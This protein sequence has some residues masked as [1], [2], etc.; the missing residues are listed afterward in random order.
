MQEVAWRAWKPLRAA[1]LRT[2][3]RHGEARLSF[4]PL[5]YYKPD[6]GAVGEA[7]A[8]IVQF[9]EL[10][11]A[12]EFP[13]LGYETVALGFPPP[14]NVDF[15]TGFQWE[16]MP[17][18]EVMPVV[19]YNG[20]DVKVPWELSRLQFLPVLAKAYLLTKDARFRQAAKVLFSDWREKNPVGVGVN[21]TL[22]MESALRGMSLCL[23]LS[24][25][26]PLGPEEQKW[27]RE[28]TRSIWE[29][30]LFTEAALE[31]SHLIRGNHYLA[32][33]VGLSCM[34]SFLDGPGME[35]RRRVYR[36][37]V[38]REMLRQVYEDG[39]NYEAS[40]CYHFLV[41]QLFTT[42][43]LLMRADGH[44]PPSPFL[45]RLR[46]MFLY[47]EALAGKDERVPHV[48]DS[49]DGRAE[50][51][52]TDL[53]QMVSLPCERRDSLLVS[54]Y[55][56]LG[57]ALFNL[58]RTHGDTSDCA[59]YGLQPR[60]VTPSPSRVSLFPQSGV[61]IGRDNGAEIVFCAIPNGIRGFGSH[62]HNDKLSI[63]A[64]LDG[65]E[66]LCDSGTCWYTR[67]IDV[68]NSFRSTRAHN[69]IRV[70]SQEQ[71]E[72]NCARRF[73]FSMTDQAGV[74]PIQFRETPD[75][76]VFSS[77]HSGFSR[78]GIVHQ[79]LI[80]IRSR[81]LLVEDT[82]QGNGQHEFEMF[83]HLPGSW[84]TNGAQKDGFDIL[85]PLEVSLRVQSNLAICCSEEPSPVSRTYG[86]ALEYG[87]C[88]KVAGQG[89]F[90]CRIKTVIA[91]AQ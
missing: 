47:L 14:W 67:K 48:G 85:V 29:H 58:T 3:I 37:N 34:A 35:R 80:R 73:E 46:A 90:P 86:G 84:R 62:T 60:R 4:R 45:A 57:G 63:L 75:E 39:G 41:L 18:K 81:R 11:C 40:F 12:G 89:P 74:A 17:A 55:L 44:D 2:K 23:L 49:D 10:I 25:M 15:V 71:N 64:R 53:R 6:L 32:N 79:R 52:A 26:Q 65:N 1:Q 83:W 24:L 22:A 72:F 68:R 5:A 69:T 66:L 77:S 28:V 19:R 54:S 9:A 20:S 59:W 76:I 16:Q 82:L 56:A 78:I 70:D 50:I 42:S 88:L 91:W 87:L 30:L 8:A 51:L 33:V 38:E 43:Y 7:A 27:G 13:F 61:A 31:L 21:W 36:R